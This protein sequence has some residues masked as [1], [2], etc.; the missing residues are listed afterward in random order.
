MTQ[1]TSSYTRPPVITVSLQDLEHGNVSLE[2][3][4]QAFGPDS[5]GI[6]LVKD[7]P[8]AFAA[9][10]RKL[11]SLSS[12]LADLPAEKLAQVERPEAR[13]NVGWSHGKEKLDS[14][15]PDLNKG[16]YYGQPIHNAELEAKARTLYP[17]LPDMTLENVWPDE[18]VLPGFASTFEEMC[19]L[20]ID[21]AALVARSC[22]RFGVASLQ[23]YKA[24][25]LENIVKTSISTK[26]R[27]LHYFP[28]PPSRAAQGRPDSA[29]GKTD[30]GWCGTHVDLGA[31]TGLTSN[32]FV[33]ESAH[34]PK[35]GQDGSLPDLP[36]LDNHPDPEAGLW[37]KDRSGRTTQVNIPRDC[38]AFQTGQALEKITRGRFR[39][40]PH[41]V[42]GGNPM[43]EG[44]R[45][46]AR[47]TLAVFTQPNLWE[48]VE[49]ETGMDFADLAKKMFER[50]Y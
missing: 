6:I 38:L 19:R 4:E 21:V 46:I 37:I 36:E 5:L 9:L 10:R 25:T 35:A 39:A 33:D 15:L 27:L 17:D 12:Y 14:G 41:F 29:L 8:E 31:L 44:S 50:T 34:P 24:G 47:N 45:G 30:D 42:R 48:V 23:G 16:S 32:L 3:L 49:E 20:I 13:Y 43:V 18:S 11:L 28:P 26:A 22:D 2:A 1:S 7:L 40:V